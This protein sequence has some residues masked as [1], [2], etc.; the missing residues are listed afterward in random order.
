MMVNNLCC[1]H[2]CLGKIFKRYKSETVKK[3]VSEHSD[4]L[5]MVI[6]MITEK[7]LKGK[8]NNLIEIEAQEYHDVYRYVFLF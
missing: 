1:D 8:M 3:V 5:K 4:I 6:P 2:N 7:V